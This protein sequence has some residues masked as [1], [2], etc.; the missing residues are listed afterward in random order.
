[1]SKCEGRC[2]CPKCAQPYSCDDK[3]AHECPSLPEAHFSKDA[4]S[5][6][7]LLLLALEEAVVRVKARIESIEFPRSRCH[8]CKDPMTLSPDTREYYC[9]TC[10][11]RAR[12]LE[13]E[14]AALKAER[15]R[16]RSR[17]RT[18]EAELASRPTPPPEDQWSDEASE[19]KEA[20]KC[21]S[22][23]MADTPHQFET[24]HVRKGCGE[25]NGNFMSSCARCC[26]ERVQKYGVVEASHELA[27]R[28]ELVLA[29]QGCFASEANED[30]VVAVIEEELKKG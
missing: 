14:G 26:Y 7:V 29:G 25:E 22:K 27:I 9:A 2:K 20:R 21:L 10:W 13:Q 15:D 1:M 8:L 5:N 16:W 11:S 4:G 6:A 12:L 23:C 17:V 18:L 28:I 30:D 24:D 3:D 19:L